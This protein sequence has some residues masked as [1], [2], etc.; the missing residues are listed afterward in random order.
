MTLST[1]LS[2]AASGLFVT[3]RATELA[4]ENIAN[5]G[6]AGFARR[7]LETSSQ[8]AGIRGVRIDAI[9]RHADPA[10]IASRRVA[11]AEVAARDGQAAFFTK[12]ANLAGTP[13][14]AG[15]LSDRLANFENTLTSAISRPDISGR[16]DAVM[17]AAG[18][19]AQGLNAVSDGLA[20]AR[21]DADSAIER[22]VGSLN[23]MLK[24]LS[25]LNSRITAVKTAGSPIEGLLDQRQALIDKVNETLP[26]TVVPRA[27]EQVALYTKGGAALLDRA[28]AQFGFAPAGVITA[29]MS[30]SSGALSGLTLNGQPFAT[31]TQHLSSGRLGALFVTRDV[32]APAL[33]D[34]LDHLAADLIQ[35]F[36]ASGLDT[37]IAPG[38]PG[39][40]TDQGAV[41]DPATIEGLAGRIALNDAV[42]PQQGGAVWKLR[43][44]LGAAVPGELGN[45]SLL[46]GFQGALADARDQTG[47][48]FGPGA[49]NSTETISALVTQI[50]L[51]QADAERAQ[52]RSVATLDELTRAEQANGV[53]TD[54]E[55][56]SLLVLERSYAANAKV[57][58]VVDEMMQWLLRI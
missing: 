37:S 42:D 13:G 45:T 2:S 39:L 46:R 49:L 17:R 7:S 18:D 47:T 15:S 14:Q 38:A 23:R 57:I 40:F 22:E 25:K 24:D 56:Q 53:D 31:T 41:Y 54:K 19:F 48:P 6:T 43:D 20:R 33:Q 16:L 44:G 28:P 35:R 29:D 12:I 9:H 4:S 10:I 55:L 3:A 52:V 50:G 32:D 58:Q 21:Q 8:V 11:A 5:V 30:L 36:E 51:G 1:A 34:T 27:N 26:V